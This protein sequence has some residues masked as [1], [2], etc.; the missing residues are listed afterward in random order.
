[1]NLKDDIDK[2]ISSE[3]ALLEQRDAKAKEFDELQKA[4][5]L[6]LRTILEQLNKSVDPT[7]LRV[8]LTDY[9]ASI[10]VGRRGDDSFEVNAQWKIE[11]KFTPREEPE[12]GEAL[13]EAQPGFSVEEVTTC[14]R[15]E[16]RQLERAY[17]FETEREVILHLLKAMAK[18][19]AHYQH[20]DESARKRNS[21]EPAS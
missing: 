3:R 12:D 13:F 15:P 11:P 8:Q 9:H 2:L 17:T 5:F 18:W 4:R 19:I 14:H 1:M 7:Y 6:P 10:E 20:L 21:K 16:F